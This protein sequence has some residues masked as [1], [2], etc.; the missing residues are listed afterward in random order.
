MPTTSINGV[1]LYWELLGQE[2]DPLVF[3]HGSWG[4]HFNWNTVVDELSKSFRVL[5]YDRRGHSK[6]ERPPGQGT[7]QED[8]S[9]LI[10]LIEYLDFV[11]AHIVG[12]SGG[13]AIV[14]KTAA[15]RPDIF[16]SLI[17]HEPPLFRVLK[18]FEEA[19]PMLE[20][21]GSRI[22]AVV[23]LIVTNEYEQAA[24]LFVETI[25]FGPGAWKELPDNVKQTFIFNA[26]TFLDE[27]RDPSNLEFDIQSLSGFHGPAL[28]T[29]GSE[30][31]PFFTMALNL[32]AQAIPQA[33]RLEFK[34]AGH[35]PHLSHPEQYVQTVRQ[36]CQSYQ[37]V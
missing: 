12:N 22:N 25:A 30:S 11:P 1:N 21:V 13:A 23:D 10:A 24:K 9:D 8:V 33:K 34:G 5:V 35:V 37:P 17:V 20:V 15:R 16:K 2:G 29:H 3:V 4:D 27:I 19:K 14:L 28:L 7:A 32:I 26:P 18:T 31:P 36:F 6:S